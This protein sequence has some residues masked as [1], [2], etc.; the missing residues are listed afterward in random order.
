MSF[1]LMADAIHDNVDAIPAQQIDMVAGYVTGSSDIVWTAA[2]WAK[3]PGIPHIAIDQGFRDTGPAEAHAYV[4]DV[5]QGAFSPDDA[6]RLMEAS[7][8]RRPTLYVNRSN[9]H[10]TIR[11]AQRSEKWKGDLWLAF[12]DWDERVSSL[13]PIP[14]GCRYVAIQFRFFPRFDMSAVL[15]DSWPHQSPAPGFTETIVRQL[16]TVSHGANGTMV[17]RIQ[18]LAK[19]LTGGPV[20]VDGIF[21][22]QTERAVRTV[23]N[24]AGIRVDGIVGPATWRALLGL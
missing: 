24:A 15:D 21:G 2:D 5:E 13:P 1:R 22:P 16:P 9:I 4:F 7:M 18:A 11:S 8:V 19:I 20:A 17:S 12:P 3:F 23:Q 10:E 6:F 14:A